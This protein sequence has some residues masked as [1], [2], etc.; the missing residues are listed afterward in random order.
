V[1]Q[2]KKKNKKNTASTAAQ[3]A[4][5]DRAGKKSTFAAYGDTEASITQLIEFTGATRQEAT[6]ALQASNGNA[7]QACADIM[8]LSVWE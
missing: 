1:L 8:M 5:T 3:S 2:K 7:H 4:Q 6:A